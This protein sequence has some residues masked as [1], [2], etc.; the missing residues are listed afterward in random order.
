MVPAA[1]E[2]VAAVLGNKGPK[3]SP[4]PQAILPLPIMNMPAS[5]IR[6]WQNARLVRGAV[7]QSA[8][9]LCIMWSMLMV[10]LGVASEGILI[11]DTFNSDITLTPAPKSRKSG[12]NLTVGPVPT[13]V[14][15]D[16]SNLWT[17]TGGATDTVNI[18]SWSSSGSFLKAHAPQLD[19]RSIWA[20]TS[21]EQVQLFADAYS[22]DHVYIKKADGSFEATGVSLKG[23]EKE[24]DSPVLYRASS[25]PD[26]P[27]AGVLV[28]LDGSG[29]LLEFDAADGEFIRDIPLNGYGAE[30]GETDWPSYVRFAVAQ[31]DAE[32]FFYLTYAGGKVYAWD[33]AGERVGSAGLTGAGEDEMGCYS[34]SYANDRLWVMDTASGA[35]KGFKLAFKAPPPPPPPTSPPPAPVEAPAATN[36]AE[37][38]G[39]ADTDEGEDD[40][41]NEED[42]K[43]SNG[44]H[45]PQD[46]VCPMATE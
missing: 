26:D 9:L 6:R 27:V 19:I 2:A 25:L 7:Q 33:K 46:D 17:A 4:N 18:M 22:D 36:A 31:V 34:I 24:T 8:L 45:L 1:A 29:A 41:N 20:Q 39:T 16:G 44:I 38:R 3:S 12:P 30:P 11:E 35:W 23:A 42:G 5:S 40:A 15:W 32:R 13:G 10:P 21:E 28:A 43:A 37:E 14:A